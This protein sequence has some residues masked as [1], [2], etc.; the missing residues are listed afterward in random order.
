MA[1]ALISSLNKGLISL[2]VQ[3]LSL[4]FNFQLLDFAGGKQ[5]ALGQKCPNV[6]LQ[7]SASKPTLAREN[8]MSSNVSL[9]SLLGSPLQRIVEGT[10]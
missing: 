3:V 6:Y 4:P 5:R 8:Q 1:G 7:L 10:A 9:K 2:L